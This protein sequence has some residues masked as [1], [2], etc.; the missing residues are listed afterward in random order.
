MKQTV[1]GII[2]LL[3]CAMFWNCKPNRS[4]TEREISIIPQPQKMTLGTSSFRFKESTEFAVES[5]DQEEIARQFAGF[6][7]RAAGWKLPIHVGVNEGS[8]QVYFKTELLMGPEAYTLDV[9]EK[10]IT[11]TAARPAGFF[12]AIQTLR[13]L[14][15]PEI[16]SKQ[17]EA[18]EEWLVPVI[19]ISDSPVFKWRGYMLDVSRHFI[20]KADVLRMIDNLSLH[21]IN[22]LHL[23]LTD[24]QGW[25]IEI[26]KYPKLTEV[27]A[28]RVDREDKH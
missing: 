21:K 1:T 25:R 7:E 16:E 18:K 2:I 24:D 19:S 8:N 9:Q 14:L 13:Q 3:C 10:R 26:K 15:P 17:I 12:Y 20:P 22:T 5:V 23:H 4:F 11:I 27:G 28:W 6:F